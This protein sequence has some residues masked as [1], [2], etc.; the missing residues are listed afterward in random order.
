MLVSAPFDDW[1]HSAYGLDVE[2]L[3]PPHTVL[4]AGIFM[5]G[6]GAVL[7]LL[8]QENRALPPEG[9][10][11]AGETGATGSRSA[12]A[13][14]CV[15]SFGILLTML[16]LF[17]TDYSYPNHQR[18]GDFYKVSCL[19]YPVF[20]VAAARVSSLRWGATLAAA[21]YMAINLLM[22]WILPLFPARPLLA[23]IYNPVD[24]M[25]PPPFPLLLVAPALGIDLVKRWVGCGP[26]RLRDW[27]LALLA[28]AAFLA[29][30]FPVHWFF[31]AFL[32]S[33]AADNWF[34][35]GTHF[36]AYFY[37]VGEW[38]REYWRT[39]IDPVTS[40]TLKR[41]LI[42]SLLSARVGLWGGNWMA[43]VKR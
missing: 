26:G 1:W 33:P 38:T 36:H 6:V 34:F 21:A 3:S 24:H 28:G 25:V 27:L 13:L 18:N 42:L 31:S 8:A 40:G 39:Q 35:A 19:A 37:P 15:Y 14:L 2:I 23:P 22:A 16:A 32:I 5:I 11:A 30:F 20:L 12:S 4:A 7:L 17:L 43:R 29:L 9:N 10:P 41:D